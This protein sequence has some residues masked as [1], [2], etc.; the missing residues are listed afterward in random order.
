M[1]DLTLPN[2]IVDSKF[3][4]SVS[5]SDLIALAI[6]S[7]IETIENDLDAVKHAIKTLDLEQ[8][9][10]VNNIKE[11]VSAYIKTQPVY[12]NFIKG[13]KP[14]QI[15]ETLVSEYVHGEKR[16][17]YMHL[18][19]NID[20]FKYPLSKIV[21]CSYENK[22]CDIIAITLVLKFNIVLENAV[23]S[24][25]HTELI[26]N[27]DYAINFKEF[28]RLQ[29]DLATAQQTLYDV[30]VQLLKIKHGNARIKSQMI[31]A[32]LQKTSKGKQLLNL[33]AKT[34]QNHNLL[35]TE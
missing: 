16:F 18:R 23:L 9:C 10:I 34:T 5:T 7:Q 19:D 4:L 30:K 33:I 32:I 25:T 31:R 8:K 20:E 22:R 12:K 11:N 14:T 17:P 1:R 21:D 28:N 35:E 29:A 26:Q 13:Y 24:Y 3:N 2:P 6:E 15:T 27:R